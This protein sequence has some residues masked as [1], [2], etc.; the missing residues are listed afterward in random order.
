MPSVSS[1]VIMSL[2]VISTYSRR[3]SLFPPGPR[4]ASGTS[5]LM[6]IVMHGR[7]T[8]PSYDCDGHVSARDDALRA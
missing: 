4:R 1:A 6:H 3:M 2:H 7:V 8:Q 5:P